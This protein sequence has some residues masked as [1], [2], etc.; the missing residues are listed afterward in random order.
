TTHDSFDPRPVR[1]ATAW[2]EFV[3]ADVTTT[4]GSNQPL[5]LRRV[6]NNPFRVFRSSRQ[7]HAGDGRGRLRDAE[8]VEIAHPTGGAVGVHR[9][10][11]DVSARGQIDR[12][13]RQRSPVLPPVAVGD[14]ELAGDVLAIHLEME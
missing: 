2:R 14:V 10:A 12:R 5:L 4:Y 6:K 9:D 7:R 11:D 8:V 1:Q 13:V 3:T